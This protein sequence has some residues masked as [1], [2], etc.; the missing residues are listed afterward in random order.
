[1]L[2]TLQEIKHN[3]RYKS[4]GQELQTVINRENRLHAHHF[5]IVQE[6]LVDVVKKQNHEAEG[7]IGV[8]QYNDDELTGI[9]TANL[10][11]DQPLTVRWIKFPTFSEHNVLHYHLV[12]FATTPYYYGEDLRTIAGLTAGQTHNNKAP[13]DRTGKK[14]SMTIFL[15]GK[16]KGKTTPLEL[17]TL[18]RHHQIFTINV[19]NVSK[20]RR[21]DPSEIRAAI[22]HT[23]YRLLEVRRARL[24]EKTKEGFNWIRGKRQS[25]NLHGILKQQWDALHNLEGR[26]YKIFIRFSKILRDKIRQQ[27][28]D[29]NETSYIIEIREQREKQ[30]A[31]RLQDWMNATEAMLKRRQTQASAEART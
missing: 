22:F 29:H 2:A 26:F 24:L 12:A 11:D 19:V 31:K 18:A 20:R 17:N 7:I 10:D 3:Q 4:Y 21:R 25:H 1:M 5:D 23:L 15:A 30:E 8:R 9:F 6:S 27:H 14:P 28:Q 16:L 13:I